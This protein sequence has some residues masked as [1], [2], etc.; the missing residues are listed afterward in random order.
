MADLAPLPFGEF[1]AIRDFTR[2]G[3]GR[4]VVEGGVD[5]GGDVIER[6]F[7]ETAAGFRDG[8][9]D[10]QVAAAGNRLSAEAQFGKDP[11]LPLGLFGC[12]VGR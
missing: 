10:C 4:F 7:A 1:A 5:C 9:D 8:H 11:G 12:V 2:I 3:R 6:A